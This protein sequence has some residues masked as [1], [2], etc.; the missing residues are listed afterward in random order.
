MASKVT[1][2]RWIHAISVQAEL[3]GWFVEEFKST[4]HGPTHI[5]VRDGYLL[6]LFARP[7]GGKLLA[8]HKVPY[9]LWAKFIWQMDNVLPKEMAGAMAVVIVTPD[10]R[11]ALWAALSDPGENTVELAS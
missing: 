4:H 6:V 7:S 9:E 2:E 8:Q 3:E 1:I 5:L 11:Q 10:S